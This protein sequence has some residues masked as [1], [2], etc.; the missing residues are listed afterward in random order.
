MA[1]NRPGAARTVVETIWHLPAVLQIAAALG[2]AGAGVGPGGGAGGG[3]AALS[4]G[5]APTDRRGHTVIRH[6]FV[7]LMGILRINENAGGIMT[8][9]P[10]LSRRRPG[11]RAG[12][13][14]VEHRDVLLV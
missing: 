6:F 12:T 7:P 14:V 3:V 8:E 1:L 2:G 9:G 4:M 5:S 10:R 13:T 11:A